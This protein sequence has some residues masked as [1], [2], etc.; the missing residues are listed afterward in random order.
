MNMAADARNMALA[1]TQMSVPIGPSDEML[2]KRFR[3]GEL[4]AGETLIKRY[5][6]PLLRYLQRLAGSDHAAE[7]LLQATWLSVLEHIEKFDPSSTSGGF[8][9]WLFR[10]ATNN[11]HEIWRS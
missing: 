8:R 1:A 9:A 10:I 6:Q 5:Q 2:L 3:D 4:A 11:A 7:E